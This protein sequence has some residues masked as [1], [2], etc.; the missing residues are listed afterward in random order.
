MFGSA[1]ARAR[2]RGRAIEVEPSRS[3][4]RGRAIEVEVEV[5][6]DNGIL[7]SRIEGWDRH[8]VDLNR[9]SIERGRQLFG[10]LT[11][12]VGDGV[13]VPYPD[14][15]FDAVVVSAVLKHIRHEDRP[16]FYDEL[17]RVGAFLLVCYEDKPAV[18]ERCGPFTFYRGD[19]RAEL[20]ARFPH[21]HTVS[22][23]GY[24]FSVYELRD[25]TAA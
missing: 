10:D 8:G 19:F 25:V 13:T 22:C 3:S 21:R 15:H 2:G 11:L 1:S 18:D 5:G 17:A 20:S 4:H 7:L 9:R 23:A 6:C 12:V 14:A 24:V 16:A